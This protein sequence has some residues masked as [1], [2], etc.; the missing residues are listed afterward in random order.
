MN[1]KL[2]VREYDF[3]GKWY[4]FGESEHFLVPVAAN[5]PVAVGF[6]AKSQLHITHSA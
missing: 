6:K 1:H 3:Y 2:S 4:D 5:L